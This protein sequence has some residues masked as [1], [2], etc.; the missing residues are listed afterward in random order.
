MPMDW[1]NYPDLFFLASETVADVANS[2]LLDPNSALKIYPPTVGTY[3]LAPSPTDFSARLQYADVYMDDLIC[4]TQGDVGQQQRASKLT[5]RDL[6]EIFPSL[7]AEVKDSVILKKA[8]H[9]DGNWS[10]VKGI[11]C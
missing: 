2:Y 5:M 9:G 4:S 3:S 6:K 1:V 8:L 11:L 10:Q 7:P